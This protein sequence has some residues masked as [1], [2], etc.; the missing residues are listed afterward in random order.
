MSL[1]KPVKITIIWEFPKT[2]KEVLKRSRKRSPVSHVSVVFRKNAV[3]DAG[4]Y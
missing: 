2:P 3:L 1:K 4:N